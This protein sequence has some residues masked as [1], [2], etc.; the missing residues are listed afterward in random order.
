MMTKYDLPLTT[1]LMNA[2][3]SLGFTP[4]DRTPVDLSRFGLFITNPISLRRRSP[5]KGR[6]LLGFSGGYLI[7]TG[8][9]NPGFRRVLSRYG[10]R[11]ALSQL[12]IL[13]H[14][15]A[16]NPSDLSYMINVLETVE[17]VNGVELGLPPEAGLDLAVSL[18]E[19]SL[20]ELPLVV[21]LPWD[22]ALEFAHALI[23]FDIMALSLAAPRGVLPGPDNSL[24]NGRL[25]GPAIFPF[26][27]AVVQKLVGTG[28]PVIGGGGVYGP[29]QLEAMLATGAVG[30]QLD[31]I[32]W[33][34]SDGVWS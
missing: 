20:G 31:G 19:A 9:P 26:A 3:G 12:P 8:H 17:G 5:A 28:I 33:Q 18:V 2:A 10:T 34:G 4:D 15:M 29:E 21:C 23:D 14:L 32:L 22:G 25:Y 30:V 27:L 16:D 7:H 1:L 13:V 11:W 24:I 6:S